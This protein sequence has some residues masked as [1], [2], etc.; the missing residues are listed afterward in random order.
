MSN[1]QTTHID[2][3]PNLEETPEAYIIYNEGNKNEYYILENHQP[4]KWFKYVRNYT[5]MHGL[6][7]THVDYDQRAWA[8]NVVN[9]NAKHQRM[10]IIPADNS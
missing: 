4:S 3:L 5:D 7:V 8:N 2:A 9:P 6:M 10:S 1:H